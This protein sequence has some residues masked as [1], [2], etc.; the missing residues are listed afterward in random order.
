MNPNDP[1]ILWGY[2]TVLALAGEGQPALEHLEKAYDLSPHI[3]IEGSADV[4]ISGVV[5]AH[6]ACGN[7]EDCITWFEKLGA[8]D[9]R[10]Y[11]LYAS[12]LKTLS[13]LEKNSPRINEFR[14]KFMNHDFSKE[15]DLFRFK[16]NEISDHCKKVCQ[17]ILE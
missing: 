14:D 10:S 16:D 15:I 8:I 4:L 5:L 11:V 3:G 17:E 12:S 9:F 6:Y 7:S 13:K 2:G 1:R